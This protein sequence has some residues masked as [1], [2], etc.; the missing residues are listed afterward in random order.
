MAGRSML[1]VG[2]VG[3]V[4]STGACRNR[5][6]RNGDAE[7]RP[8]EQQGDDRRLSKQHRQE[9]PNAPTESTGP[10]GVGPPAKGR[11]QPA[12]Q[13]NSG[14][15]PPSQCRWRKNEAN[16]RAVR[17]KVLI[18]RRGARCAHR[19]D[20]SATGREA[21]FCR[22][23]FVF[24]IYPPNAQSPTH[25]QIGDR[26]TAR[27]IL[28]WVHAKFVQR[29]DFRV[30]VRPDRTNPRRPTIYIFASA[31]DLRRHL[32]GNRSVEPIATADYH[33]EGLFAKSPWPVV[34]Q[35]PIKVDGRELTAYRVA[36]LGEAREGDGNAGR[37]PPER[38]EDIGDRVRMVDIVFVIDAT[39][40]MQQE[41]DA[42]K[43]AAKKI[44]S[45]ATTFNFGPDVRLG[46]VEYRDY[47][48]RL[49]YDR[50]AGKVC[51]VHQLAT[52][53]RFQDEIKT[54]KEADHSSNDHPEAVFDGVLAALT[55]VQWRGRGLSLRAIVLIGDSHGHEPGDPKNRKNISLER[56][57]KEAKR[58]NIRIFALC[59]P[60]EGGPRDK[61]MHESQF[62]ILA[63]NTGGEKHDIKD[64]A[65]VTRRIEEIAKDSIQR[66]AMRAKVVT[67]I[68]KGKPPKVVQEE[69]GLREYTEVVKLLRSVSNI[70]L[71]QLRGGRPVFATG[72][73]AMSYAGVPA[74][75]R[76]DFISKAEL[77][78]L[79]SELSELVRVLQNDPKK[80]RDL[81]DVA[82]RSRTGDSWFPGRSSD[83][84]RTLAKHCL[85]MFV[86]V[87]QHSILNLTMGQL[88]SM[89]EA[90][91]DVRRPGRRELR[92]LLLTKY[93][94]TLSRML[95]SDRFPQTGDD[96]AFGWIDETALP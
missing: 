95:G 85:A 18:K 13:A 31:D 84:N 49:Y 81:V 12:W 41:I 50:K 33:Y 8:D 77:A 34:D 64:A 25:Y 60:N 89:P 35:A 74:F 65:M 96:T 71:E 36:L 17:E 29:W 91:G 21:A 5:H 63:M 76:E 62:E 6:E 92:Q 78:F 79:L 3:L 7:S 94:P 24:D 20:G 53:E 22:P 48:D 16:V 28:G 57:V 19:P 45:E 80:T 66:A 68:H 11:P 82:F 52:L 46:V 87:G 55:E 73:V 27:S 2:A 39:R 40:S 69:V 51:K 23:Y 75:R 26:P 1:A 32:S 67:D 38:P 54:V 61:A 90:T 70:K 58:R 9:P 47:V 86:P 15:L 37:R 30:G 44:A 93:I 83:D 72:W 4:L 56:L 10:R 43:A 42:A 88:S 14:R 59:C